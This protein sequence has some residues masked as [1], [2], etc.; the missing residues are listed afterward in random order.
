MKGG[1]VAVN[2]NPEL[3]IGIKQIRDEFEITEEQF[4][5]FLTM[6]LPVRKINNRWYGHRENI[7]EFFRRITVGQ[8]IQVDGA[9]AREIAGGAE[10]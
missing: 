3:M 6:G 10:E 2:K 4:Y 8:P 9:R 1:P 7:S 5:V